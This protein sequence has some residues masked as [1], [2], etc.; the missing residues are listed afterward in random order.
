MTEIIEGEAVEVIEPRAVMVVQQPGQAIIAADTPDGPQAMLT[1]ATAIATALSDMVER[2]KLYTVISG[3]KFPAVEAWQT[4]GRMDNVVAREA[5]RPIRHDD[6]SYEAFVELVRLSD[7]MVIGSASALCGTKD[8]VAGRADWSKRAEPHRRSMAVTR[9]TSRAFRQ[10]Y[11][12]IMALAGYEPT[13]A[14]EMDEHTPAA[15]RSVS[16]PP[17]GDAVSWDGNVTT[18]P[19]AD[20][21]VRTD[22]NRG[23]Y[24]AFKLT[25]LEP[26]PEGYRSAQ[27][28]FFGDLGHAVAV[29]IQ[30]H[31]LPAT[32]TVWGETEVAG[33]KDKQTG[34]QVSY[35]VI[36]A[37]RVM[38]PEWTIPAS[39]AA[40]A[41][42]PASVAP[43][44]SQDELDGLAW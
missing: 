18:T 35:L 9:A 43:G 7:G 34:Q 16:S 33:F 5:S 13:P 10:Q 31:G 23:D 44:A 26:A 14:E 36:N 24:C 17:A 1:R 40:P 37:S 21:S 2:Q 11:A 6:G 39:D 15:P 41:E 3:K 25:D 12:W 8:D 19:S 28:R 42:A 22:R 38:T 4:I 27:V 20:G 30:M 29:A 32:A